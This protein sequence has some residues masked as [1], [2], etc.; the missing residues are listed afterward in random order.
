MK[1]RNL[2]GCAM[3]LLFIL[4]G[5]N[6]QAQ[7]KKAYIVKEG[8]V[9]Y[10]RD[11]ADIDSI[12]FKPTLAPSFT[13]HPQS[14]SVI[15]GE[16][17]TI[18]AVATGN[19]EPAYY[20]QI[21]EPEGTIW[22]DWT[23]L[24]NPTLTFNDVREG[25]N[26]IKFRCVANNGVGGDANHNVYSNVATTT[27]T[28][29]FI[30][31]IDIVGVPTGGTIGTPLTLTGTVIPGNANN[32]TITW[33]AVSLSTE[34]TASVVGNAIHTNPFTGSFILGAIVQV[35][36]IID[37]GASP[38]TPFGMVFYI[39]FNS[40]SVTVTPVTFTA[41]QTGGTS[42]TANSTGIKLTFSQSVSGLT[43]DRITITNGTGEVTKGTLTGSGTTW[44]I[45][46]TNITAQGNVTVTVGDYFGAFKVTNNPQTVAVYKNGPFAGDGT[47]D[48]PWRITNAT[49]LNKLSEL[50]NAGTAPY[51]DAGKYYRLENN[52]SLP[53]AY[54]NVMPI[55]NLS[56]RAFKG[57]FEGNN[58]TISGLTN[59]GGL[60]GYVSGGKI[61]NLGLMNVN[62]SGP[63][64]I[65]GT[66]SGS[67]A[68]ITGCYVTGTVNNVGPGASA[69]G[70]AAGVG[71]GVTIS[72]CYTTCSVTGEG[73]Y[74]GGIVG[75]NGGTV[76][77]CYATGA[78][79]STGY[80]CYV[81]GIVAFNDGT[82][83]N[84]VALNLSISAFNHDTYFGRVV[85]WNSG[86][87]TDN[88]SFHGTTLPGGTVFGNNGTGIDK[89]EVRDQNT[90]TS[91]GWSF[92]T[93]T[94]SPWRWGLSN[95]YPLPTLHWQIIP[96]GDLPA[97]L[98]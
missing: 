28:P 2:L 22:N 36:A 33:S 86:T 30:P 81:G 44:T 95:S 49:D 75:S 15:V 90:Y 87:L 13:T 71:S 88:A 7:G 62:I 16:N 56:S 45:G 89:N 54:N 42:G 37:N 51:A 4:S 53:V 39:T 93:T 96:P 78:I 27:V 34:I 48:S 31:V 79:K 52:I 21:Q 38:T 58:K 76:S 64:G 72:N 67:G 35:I 5:M 61:Q 77:K 63:G 98:R 59:S 47:S 24:T 26:G 83:Q 82:V 84:C 32:R 25:M 80:T 66:I 29:P 41:V 3:I 50:I 11:V 60:F 18:A 57:I 74:V 17:I 94:A 85:G 97:H 43:A 8:A 70:I 6:V 69:G 9:L 23:L 73:Q 19:P 20:W 14:Q 1:K 12:V 68:S 10:A 55:G 92:G 46:L 65:A 91:R 40:P